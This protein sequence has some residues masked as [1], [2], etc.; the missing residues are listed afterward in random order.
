M[1]DE[2]VGHYVAVIGGATAGA[3]VASRL[4]DR[5]VS[6]FVFEQNRRPYGK[7]EDGLPRWHEALRKKE[8][9]TI[10]EKLSKA[11]VSFVPKTKIGRD[12]DFKELVND[13]GFSAVVLANGAW[14]DRPV[15]IEGAEAYVGKGLA[16]QNP[17]VIAFN[18][19]ERGD[20]PEATYEVKD[21]AIILGGGLA[22]ID[23]AKIHTLDMTLGALEERGIE[24]NI[25]E[26]E[27][28]GI[29]KTLDK[30]GLTW[31]ELGIE[32]A[33]IYYRRR[34]E[35]MPLMSA[36]EGADEVRIK[37]V[38]AGRKRMLDKSTGKYMFKVE[39]LSAPDD[40]IVE[41]GQLV[42]IV[43]RRTR[44][45][46]GR[47]IKLDGT[48]EVRS[49]SVLSSIGSIPEAIP[50]IAMKGELFDFKDWD[51]GRLEGYPTVFSVGNVVT[52]KGNIV[53]SRK[54][55]THV[56]EEAIEA[57]LGVSDELDKK[58]REAALE[59]RMTHNRGAETAD[60][61]LESLN[62]AEAPSAEK[63]QSLLGK[64]AALHKATGF[65]DYKSWLK[66][67]GEPC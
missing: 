45:E 12:I 39:P 51:I 10:D 50:G 15:P 47:V 54:H 35:D 17:F 14:H 41:N 29:P 40:L 34:V 18:H 32:G 58:G 63:V 43:F 5:G 53:A 52:G 26:L 9:K 22:S 44:I 28:K 23:V 25:E 64:V 33:T 20:L 30:H 31:E 60:N 2:A 38:E 55:A 48:Y 24:T 66:K 19:A 21:G 49:P 16:Y 4:A 46:N 37:K 65:E 27:I 57:Y 59:A 42:G 3:E 13:W 56:S 67:V 8:Y 1:T 11:G 62:D 61:V 6:V 36:P 7:I